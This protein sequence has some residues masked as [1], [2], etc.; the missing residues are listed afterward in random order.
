MED[1]SAA[2]ELFFKHDGSRFYMSR[3]DV[4]DVYTAY[5]VPAALEGQW[6]EELTERKLSLLQTSGNWRSIHFF[7][8]HRDCRELTAVLQAKPLGLL[9]QR[10]NFVEEQLSYVEMCHRQGSDLSALRAGTQ[11]VLANARDLR[12]SCRSDRSR[13]R[14]YRLIAEAEL[15]NATFGAD[16]GAPRP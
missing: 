12:R 6:L 11:Q 5:A 10:I 16:R 15:A 9:W 13:S 2:K 3:N 4:E 14:V 8:D 1:F 7:V